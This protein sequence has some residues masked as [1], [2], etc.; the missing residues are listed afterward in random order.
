VS[1]AI[2]SRMNDVLIEL[3]NHPD[4]PNLYWALSEF[5]ARRAILRRSWD[6]EAWWIFYCIPTLQKARA[7]EELTADQW[8]TVL[9]DD[10]APF[11]SIAENY[12]TVRLRPHPDPIKDAPPQTLQRAQQFYAQSHQ[13]AP[14]Q[15]AKVDPAILLGN[16]YYHEYEVA[17][18]EIAK[19]R[20]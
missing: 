3:M 14:E 18:D 6:N 10:T 11:Y 16:L 1:L 2:T 9:V 12:V 8:R 15:A 7:G 13:I 5:P 20:G 17:S 4:S 19:L